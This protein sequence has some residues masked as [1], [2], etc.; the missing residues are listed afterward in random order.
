MAITPLWHTDSYWVI[1]LSQFISDSPDRRLQLDYWSHLE[2][3]VSTDPCLILTQLDDHSWFL[4]R[5]FSCVTISC[6]LPPRSLVR[7]L[8]A[9]QDRL[10]WQPVCLSVGPRLWPFGP[11]SCLQ[12]PSASFKNQ[13]ENQ[14]SLNLHLVP[15]LLPEDKHHYSHFCWSYSE[16]PFTFN[17][18]FL[19]FQHRNPIN[20]EVMKPA[21]KATEKPIVCELHKHFTNGLQATKTSTAAFYLKQTKQQ[22]FFLNLFYFKDHFE[23]LK[24]PPYQMLSCQGKKNVHC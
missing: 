16:F 19:L 10:P 4:P 22:G 11:T 3:L 1:F 7:L 17:S 8:P 24:A 14:L 9:V 5:V 13:Q 2:L 18:V 6:H 15:E 23:N 12:D 21:S 20:T